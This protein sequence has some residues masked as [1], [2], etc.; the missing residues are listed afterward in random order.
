M[1]AWAWLRKDI[2][3]DTR[4]IERLL[5]LILLMVHASYVLMQSQPILHCVKAYGILYVIRWFSPKILPFTVFTIYLAVNSFSC[6]PL[7][8]FGKLFGWAGFSGG[9]V[10]LIVFVFAFSNGVHPSFFYSGFFRWSYAGLIEWSLAFVLGFVLVYRR[11]RDSLLSVTFAGLLL[12]VGGMIYE[13]PIY[14]LFPFYTHGVW[15]HAAF[16]LFISTDW[17][18][19]VFTIYLLKKYSWRPTRIFWVALVAYLIHGVWYATHPI[20]YSPVEWS[21]YAGWLPRFFGIFLLLSLPSG[22]RRVQE[23]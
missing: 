13:L 11:T 4:L 19:L 21:F 16:P 8:E 12:S 23:H 14:Y 3:V 15:T 7:K 2:P 9:F 1:K 6:H 18:S 20:H 5:V 17:F 10:T 22:I